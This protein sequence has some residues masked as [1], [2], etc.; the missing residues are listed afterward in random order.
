MLR[1][2]MHGHV[3]T[4]QI[5]YKF[6]PIRSGLLETV[7]PKFKDQLSIGIVRQ[8][9]IGPSQSMKLISLNIYFDQVNALTRFE[10]IVERYHF[11]GNGPA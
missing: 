1:Y 5:V 6:N 8:D 4:L 7:W 2:L 3:F 10:I 11:S 9:T